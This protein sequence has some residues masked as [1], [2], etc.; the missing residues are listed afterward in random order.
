[1]AD[2]NALIK[3]PKIIS[4]LRNI[5]KA[6]FNC[7]YTDSKGK[8]GYLSYPP[9]KGFTPRQ[10]EEIVLLEISGVE[11]IDDKADPKDDLRHLKHLKKLTLGE[12]VK[13]ISR[14]SIPTSLSEIILA[15]GVSI[16]E[17]FVSMGSITKVSAPGVT[18]DSQ[19]ANYNNTFFTDKF[20][21]LHFTRSNHLS[22]G[23]IG[24]IDRS[25]KNLED[26][27][28]A[29]RKTSAESL[30]HHS[31]K[32]PNDKTLYVYAKSISSGRNY[33]IHAVADT[34]PMPE[35]HKTELS[36]ENLIGIMINGV[37]EFDVASLDLYPNLQTVYVGKSVDKV[38]GVRDPYNGG[39][40]G[41]GHRQLLEL[42]KSGKQQSIVLLSEN[43]VPITAPK[44]KSEEPVIEQ[45]EQS[46]TSDSRDIEL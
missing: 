2:E 12:G 46:I 19:Y 29:L 6:R 26:S 33:S 30:L 17:S 15:E 9:K 4:L 8:I 34:F 43:T 10:C 45:T 25:G 28:A 42:S 37:P 44:A 16:P 14:N 23:E 24:V 5:G 20:G 36:D 18:F 35:E 3:Q 1:M 38:T 39:T 11:T 27:A 7:K 40:D 41:R 32:H 21:R 22:M 31:S 13:T